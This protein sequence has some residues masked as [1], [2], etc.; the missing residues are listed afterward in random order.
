VFPDGQQVWVTVA[1]IFESESAAQ[2]EA[3]RLGMKLE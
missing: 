3:Q 2:V 1:H